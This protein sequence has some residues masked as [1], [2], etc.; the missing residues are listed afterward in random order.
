M[1]EILIETQRIWVCD[2][3]FLKLNITSGILLIL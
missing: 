2:V 1:D 3:N